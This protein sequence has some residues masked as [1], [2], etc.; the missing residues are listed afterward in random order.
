MTEGPSVLEYLLWIVAIG[1]LV[2]GALVLATRNRT[3]TA[4]TQ[5]FFAA[6]GPRAA[7]VVSKRTYNWPDRVGYYVT[8]QYDGQPPVEVEVTQDWYGYLNPGNRGQLTLNGNQFV[9]FNLV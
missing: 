3:K 7:T 5:A 1:G 8:F 9:Q 2:A 6:A 4:R